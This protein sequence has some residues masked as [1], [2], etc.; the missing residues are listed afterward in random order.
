M[1]TGMLAPAARPI[2]AIEVAMLLQNRRPTSC[3]YGIDFRGR[4]WEQG[5]STCATVPINSRLMPRRGQHSN[6]RM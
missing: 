3:I 5:Y 4:S 2:A 1:T 6:K